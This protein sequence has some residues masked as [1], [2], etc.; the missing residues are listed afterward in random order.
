METRQQLDA[1]LQ[2]QA[3]LV[4]R[5]RCRLIHAPIE[6][7]PL[8]P[9]AQSDRGIGLSGV[10]QDLDSFLARHR[11]AAAS[12]RVATAL[13]YDFADVDARLVRVASA[14]ASPGRY[15]ARAVATCGQGVLDR[16]IIV[17]RGEWG[18][19]SRMLP[20]WRGRAM[21]LLTLD[22]AGAAGD[23]AYLSGV[24]ER[25]GARVRVVG[26]GPGVA[27][28]AS[29]DGASSPAA[30][31]EGVIL[32]HLEGEAAARRM[33]ETKAPRRLAR[34]VVIAEGCR[35][36]S[37]PCP[38]R[39]PRMLGFAGGAVRVCPSSP[40][41]GDDW[42]ALDARLEARV[43]HVEETR[44]CADCPAR[45]QC[46]RCLHTGAIPEA[47]Y[48]ELRR[49]FGGRPESDPGWRQLEDSVDR[50]VSLGWDD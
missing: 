7:E 24:T 12:P 43:R 18:R 33:L 30:R 36:T 13:G 34:G 23:W 15:F 4:R 42:D 17:G 9:W 16:Q 2:W 49:T 45:E 35:W 22:R 27:R 37:R 48:C 20:R 31:P 40:D 19:A 29:W 46:P 41:L 3:R 10:R 14:L 26:L 28:H 25:L 21:T 44:G 50:G 11:P 5:F 8:A 47:A 39:E 6:L 32:L 38:A 1:S